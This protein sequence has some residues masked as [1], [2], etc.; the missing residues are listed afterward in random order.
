MELVFLEKSAF[1]K[2]I[3]KIKSIQVLAQKIED[4]KTITGWLDNQEICQVLDISPR[5]LQ[6]L[7]DKKVFGRTRKGN[8]FYYKKSVIESFLKSNYKKGKK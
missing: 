4:K 6:T 3:E 8:K 5:T 2:L 7:R 1:D